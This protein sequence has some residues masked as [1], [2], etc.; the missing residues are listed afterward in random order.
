MGQKARRV[1]TSLKRLQKLF[2]DRKRLVSSIPKLQTGI[3]SIPARMAGAS[4]EHA[5]ALRKMQ[6]R[7]ISYKNREQL[8]LNRIPNRVHAAFTTFTT[9]WVSF[10]F[11][12]GAADR[13]R[14]QQEQRNQQMLK[15]KQLGQMP[16]NAAPRQSPKKKTSWWS[17]WSLKNLF[18]RRQRQRAY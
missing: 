18:G 1:I 2:A 14:L 16:V 12:L 9:S 11:A 3:D 17:S 8:K 5:K 4:L 10:R 13:A 15:L 7:L 6:K